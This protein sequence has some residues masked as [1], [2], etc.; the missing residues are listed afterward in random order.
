ML[1]IKEPKALQRIIL[2]L[3]GKRS[4]GFVPTMGALHEGH[5]SLIRRA[6]K[7]NDLVAVS[8]FI[9]PKQFGPKEDLKK[10]PRQLNKDLYLCRKEKVDFVFLPGVK[11]M[12]PLNYSTIVDV[13]G[14]SN[15]LCGRSRPGHFKGVATIVLKLL[16]IT[17]PNVLYLGQKDF[18]Q[19]TIIKKMVDDLNIPVKVI[20][21]PTVREKSGL[22]LSSRNLYLRGR[23]KEDALALSRSLKTASFL[24]KDGVRDAASIIKKMRAVISEKKS[25]KIDYLE[26]VDEK[27]LMPLKKIAGNCLIL[28]A[29]F[30]GK[31]RL[32][33]NIV[34]RN[35]SCSNSRG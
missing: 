7:D 13:E 17:Q 35:I 3:K 30:I 25:A 5:L 28:I 10:Y 33:D 14:L 31:T 22:A 24:I 29:V 9:N 34:I 19:A 18:Q 23:E 26:I 32:I 20:V 1:I 11:E 4:I 8:I 15:L 2:K 27:N 12:Y 6:R 21:M 16:N